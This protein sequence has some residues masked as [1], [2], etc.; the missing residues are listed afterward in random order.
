MITPKISMAKTQ[1]GYLM[2]EDQIIEYM[3][4]NQCKTSIS[5]EIPTVSTLL[6]NI[7]KVCME[8]EIPPTNKLIKPSTFYR[9]QE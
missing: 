2:K 8:N 3:F 6:P 5:S 4:P 9:L 1:D 7:P